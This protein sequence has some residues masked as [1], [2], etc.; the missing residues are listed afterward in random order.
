MCKLITNKFESKKI[1]LDGEENEINWCFLENLNELQDK[2]GLHLA[3]KITKRHLEF[4][5]NIMKLK[6]ATHLLSRS[7]ANALKFCRED[8]YLLEFKSS[9]ATETCILLWNHLFDIFNSRDLKQHGFS[10]PIYNGN[11]DDVLNYLE[12]AKQYI[13]NLNN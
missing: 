10:H 8:L 4:C 3:N 11:K 12:C 9:E 1:F 13:T 2:E 5:S 6:F 7:G